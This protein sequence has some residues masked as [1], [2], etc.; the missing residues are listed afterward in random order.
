MT[1]SAWILSIAGVVVLSILLDLFLPDGKLNSYIKTMFNF[2]I[3]LVVITPLPELLNKDFD[4][5]TMF[6]NS[7]IVLQEDYIYQLNRD[8]LTMLETS[9]ENTLDSNGY[10]NIDV[11]ISANIF[12]IEMK[13]ETIFVDLTNLVIQQN[14]ENINIKKEVVECITSIVNISKENIVFSEWC[15][16]K[17]LYNRKNKK[18]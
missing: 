18:Y 11:S 8:K 4:T 16:K 15:Q 1:I 3:I 9:I 13:I 12:V 2:V 14:N 6:S 10:K 17:I 5:S 7:Q